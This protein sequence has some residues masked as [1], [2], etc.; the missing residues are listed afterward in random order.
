MVKSNTI[1]KFGRIVPYCVPPATVGAVGDVFTTIM[2]NIGEPDRIGHP[3]GMLVGAPGTGKTRGLNE[4]VH[5]LTKRCRPEAAEDEEGRA[6]LVA[7][8]AGQYGQVDILIYTYSNGNALM[9]T[10]GKVR[11]LQC[12]SARL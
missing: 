12:A 6:A 2:R 8:Q 11:L 4:L 7:L 5:T 9:E 10:D 3:I 1:N